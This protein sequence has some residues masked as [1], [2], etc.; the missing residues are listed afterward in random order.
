VRPFPSLV[1]VEAAATKAPSLGRAPLAEATLAEAPP[2]APSA[3]E[4]YW[5]AVA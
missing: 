3:A 4:A 5:P 2:G 1:E